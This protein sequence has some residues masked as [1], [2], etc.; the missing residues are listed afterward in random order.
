MIA[1]A[2]AACTVG[3]AIEARATALFAARKPLLAL[4]LDA[5]GNEL[6]FRLADRTFARIRRDARRRSWKAGA[7]LSPGNSGIG[8][9]QQPAIL[10]LSG[11]AENR[12][13]LTSQG[14][15]VPAKSL[16]FVVTLGR[17]LSVRSSERCDH[18]ASKDRC[19]LRNRRMP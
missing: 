6:L 4:A 8:L 10:S 2:A 9:D 17:N 16:C 18:C 1:I 14:M 15:L 11:A 19:Q 3:P 5:A 7:E 12:I 13:A